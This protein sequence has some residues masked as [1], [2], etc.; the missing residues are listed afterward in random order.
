MRM[1]LGLVLGVIIGVGIYSYLSQSRSSHRIVVT[2]QNTSTN[3]EPWIRTPLNKD[4]LKDE[5]DRTGQVIREK[6]RKAGE[7]IADATANG[8][9]TAE[10]KAKLI[11]DSGLA[12]F[13]ID[14]NTTD[15]VVTLSGAVSSYD[16]IS[17]AIDIAMEVDGVVKVISTLQVKTG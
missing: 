10:I 5:L 1:L 14:V 16:Q 12:A 9:I 15:G 17:H 13:K 3:P 4:R 2:D 8:R 6:A 11:K 7:V